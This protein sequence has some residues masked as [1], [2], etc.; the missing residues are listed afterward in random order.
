MAAARLESGCGATAEG[1]PL[2]PAPVSELAGQRD[3]FEVELQRDQH[4]TDGEVLPMPTAGSS[5][6]VVSSDSSAEPGWTQWRL[7]ARGGL[8]GRGPRVVFPVGIVG[9]AVRQAE[10]ARAVCPRPP[11]VTRLDVGFGGLG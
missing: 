11:V 3:A 9:A 2:P 1:H 7:A 10:E 5:R 6:P 4:S 8:S